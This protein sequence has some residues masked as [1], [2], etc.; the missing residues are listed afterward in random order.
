MK[1][2]LQL[3]VFKDLLLNNRSVESVFSI[4]LFHKKSAA[5][6]NRVFR[7]KKSSQMKTLECVWFSFCFSFFFQKKE[8]EKKT[9]PLCITGGFVY[10]KTMELK[11]NERIDDLQWGGLKIIQNPALFC[12]G[13]DSVLLAGFVRVGTGET[14][15]DL[16]TGSGVLAILTGGKN[17]GCRV[18]GSCLSQSLRR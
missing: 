16:G 6:F 18:Y 9:D 5:Q 10:N 13:T 7:K 17:P 2:N 3:I 15:A 1:D 4:K 11:E 14:V 8:K 12:F